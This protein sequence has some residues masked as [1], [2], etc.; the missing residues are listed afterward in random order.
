MV[1]LVIGKFSTAG[2]TGYPPYSGIEANPGVGVG[3]LDLGAFDQRRR[4]DPLGHQLHR[5][6]PEAP[7]ARDGPDAHD[8]VHLDGAL[9]ISVLMAFAFPALT[10]ACGPAGTRPPARHAFLHERAGRQT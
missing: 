6:H 2:W 1:S 10:V 5:H 9:R 8:A 3:L 4:L 7:R